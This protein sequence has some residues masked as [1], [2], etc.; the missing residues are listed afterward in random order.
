M[1]LSYYLVGASVLMMFITASCTNRKSG[2]Y[3]L[4]FSDAQYVTPD[5]FHIEET[6]MFPWGMRAIGSNLITANGKRD[7]IF[8]AFT[9]PE[10][11]YTSSGIIKGAGPDEVPFAI[12]TTLE[13]APQPD[14]LTFL[15]GVPS[16]LVTIHVPD[17]HIVDKSI[18]K[19]PEGWP[20]E[21]NMVKLRGD[22]VVAQRYDMPLNW[23][24]VDGYGN[25]VASLDIPVPDDIMTAAGNDQWNKLVIHSAIGLPSPDGSR[26]AICTK[27]YPSVFIF[28]SKGNK[29]NTVTMPYIAQIANYILCADSNREAIYVCYHDPSDKEY[30]ECTIAVI[31]W[32]GNYIRS[33]IVSGPAAPITVNE[34]GTYLYYR[35]NPEDENLYRI[36]L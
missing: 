8:D 1:Q 21:Q 7:T 33:Y 25:T 16:E 10:I 30:K 12:L 23:I 3:E 19:M 27:V 20:G 5:T 14:C 4:D 22:T 2:L 31:D 18:H 35:G 24:I 13:R 26:V 32:N 17:F 36:K 29:I 11:S 6:I 15:S 9:I 34:D 28:D